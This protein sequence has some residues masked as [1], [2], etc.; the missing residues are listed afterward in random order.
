MPVGFLG[1]RV[2]FWYY[3]FCIQC[4]W[5]SNWSG[6][7]RW[8]G[9]DGEWVVHHIGGLDLWTR[10]KSYR[11]RKYC[12]S[13]AARSTVFAETSAA[14]AFVSVRRKK[15]VIS[16]LDNCVPVAFSAAPTVFFPTFNA[17]PVKL[18]EN[19]AQKNTFL[20]PENVIMFSSTFPLERLTIELILI[21]L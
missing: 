4:S 1:G 9:W 17:H 18:F 10:V 5:T 21:T 13:P 15:L 6:C 20:P 7:Y 19:G 3:R 16:L 12:A 11:A 2:S 8:R 14:A